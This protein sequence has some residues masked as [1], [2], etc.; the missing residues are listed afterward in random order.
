MCLQQPVLPHDVEQ[1]L[2]QEMPFLRIE[3]EDAPRSASS[4]TSSA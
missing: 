3:T 2:D 1:R 4:G